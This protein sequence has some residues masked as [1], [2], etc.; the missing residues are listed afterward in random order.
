M[1][2]IG[3]MH[4]FINPSSIYITSRGVPKFTDF[5]YAKCMD[6]SLSYTICGDPLYFAPEIIT[7]K[8]IHSYNISIN[9]YID[10]RYKCID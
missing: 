1:G 5:R 2:F 7:S 3:L 8:G 4:R 10:N 9:Q 6:G